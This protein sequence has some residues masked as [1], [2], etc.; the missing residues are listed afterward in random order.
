MLTSVVTKEPFNPAHPPLM[1]DPD[2]LPPTETEPELVGEPYRIEKGSFDLVHD[3]D[4]PWETMPYG[5]PT[6]YQQ[7]Q[8]TRQ[9]KLDEVGYYLVV[10][11][12]KWTML[13][14]KTYAA[15]ETDTIQI[16]QG[17][18]YSHHVET[19]ESVTTRIGV[20]LGLELSGDLFAAAELP[21]ATALSSTNASAN[22]SNQ[23]L[24]ARL[25]AEMSRTLG[26]RQTDQT[27]YD[28]RTDFTRTIQFKANMQYLSWQVQEIVTVSRIRLS[29]E[30]AFCSSVVSATDVTY[31]Q[32][33]A[34]E[35]SED[36]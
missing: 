36:V 5:T 34:M 17:V 6:Q 35:R 2:L 12:R 24:S 22:E 7:R 25:T 27:T 8:A 21:M 28:K 31:V 26:F 32:A 19:D 18:N 29:G 3:P 23:G 4:Y 14:R 16:A 9:R 10:R 15:D 1:T 33:F 20:D 13:S 11:S 30:K